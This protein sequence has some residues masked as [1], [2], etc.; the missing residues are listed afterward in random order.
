[1]ITKPPLGA[2]FCELNMTVWAK[3][4]GKTIELN[5]RASEY[6]E[7]IGF[8]RVKDKKAGGN[9]GK[10]GSGDKRRSDRDKSDA[11]R[12]ADTL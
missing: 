11:S 4:C 1:M 10:S 8:K 7:S 5:D 6:A 9:S 2:Y 3:P 12:S